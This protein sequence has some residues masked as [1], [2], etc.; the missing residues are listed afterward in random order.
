M[1]RFNGY[2]HGEGSFLRISRL[3][4]LQLPPRMSATNRR[5]SPGANAS[6]VPQAGTHRHCVRLAG[7]EESS[8]AEALEMHLKSVARGM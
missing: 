4:A 8:G 2:R 7:H 1:P 6:A 3:V 5:Y